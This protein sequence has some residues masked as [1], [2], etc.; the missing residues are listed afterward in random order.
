MTPINILLLSTY[1]FR[2]PRHGGQIRLS[3]ITRIYRR[4]GFIVYPIAI[5]ESEIYCH[6]DTNPTDIPFPPSSQFRRHRGRTVPFINDLVTGKFAASEEGAFWSILRC[7]P[8]RIDVIHI[9]QP[10]LLPLAQRLLSE[11]SACRHACLVYGSQNIEAVLKKSIFESYGMNEFGDVLQEIDALERTAANESDLAF[12]VTHYDKTALENFGAQNVVLAPN[13]VSPW[14]AAERRLEYWRSRLPK[15]PWVLFIAS[16]HPPNFTGF[17]QSVGDSLACIPPNSR[18]IVV[19]TV[20]EHIFRILSNTRWR[21]INL[22]RLTLL[23]TLD[24]EDL[25]AVKTL[26]HA[27]LV[28][29]FD[30]GGSNLK[31]AEAL[32]SGKYV[33]C[34]PASIRGFEAYRSLPELTI[35]ESPGESQAAI[36]DVLRRPPVVPGASEAGEIRERLR[37]DHCL[38]ALPDAV[39]RLVKTKELVA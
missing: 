34:T 31:T 36:H 35:V 1:P 23:H 5:Y 28:P 25:A 37:W 9:E 12:A 39:I 29:I 30:G 8:A 16:A 21:D 11:L 14:L 26:A 4:R 17:V 27:F 6:D 7:L 32:Y 24:D 20:G 3:E 10:W 2:K 33:I 19:G 15:A 18:L 13:G 38:A 22:S